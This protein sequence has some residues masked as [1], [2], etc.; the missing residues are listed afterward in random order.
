MSVGSLAQPRVLGTLLKKKFWQ[1]HDSEAQATNR[2]PKHSKNLCLCREL[3]MSAMVMSG[4]KDAGNKPTRK[5]ACCNRQWLSESTELG[6]GNNHVAVSQPAAC[7]K[8]T[9]IFAL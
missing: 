5:N 4:L 9:E 7:Q 2:V 6:E 3:G 8:L 1:R